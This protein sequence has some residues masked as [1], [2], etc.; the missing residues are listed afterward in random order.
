M[1]IKLKGT[2]FYY[3]HLE[4][5]KAYAK[6]VHRNRTKYLLRKKQGNDISSYAQ[7]RPL[8]EG[9]VLYLSPELDMKRTL[10]NYLWV[11]AESIATPPST[12]IQAASL[13]KRT[14]N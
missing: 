7:K 6:V 11:S 3:G 12:N 9:E 5:N 2:C 10:S 8:E 4:P 13:L 14:A 1:N